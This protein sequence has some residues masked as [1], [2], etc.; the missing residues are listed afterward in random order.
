MIRNLNEKTNRPLSPFKKK[1]Y[2]VA[3]I[4]IFNSFKVKKKFPKV[5]ELGEF[6]VLERKGQ[7][8]NLL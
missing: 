2:N 1:V 5:L 8:E 7:R 4:F 6:K 3:S